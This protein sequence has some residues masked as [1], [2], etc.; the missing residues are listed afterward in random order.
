MILSTSSNSVTL[1]WWPPMDNGSPIN[2][3]RLE[4]DQGRKAEPGSGGHV[5]SYELAYAGIATTATVGGLHHGLLYSFRLGLK[6][7]RFNLDPNPLIMASSIRPGY[8][9]RIQRGRAS[10]ALRSSHLPLQSPP[11]PH[12]L[13]SSESSPRWTRAQSHGTPLMI[14]VA[15]GWT[16]MRFNYRQRVQRRLSSWAVTG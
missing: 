10:G 16:L 6:G 5:S 4:V 7:F 9:L 15:V 13:L 2:S 1:V 12:P 8:S 11:I 14:T 3:Y